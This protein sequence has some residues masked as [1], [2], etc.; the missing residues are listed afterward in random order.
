M[1]IIASLRFT[2][3]HS[4]YR[5]FNPIFLYLVMQKYAYKQKIYG[6]TK[7]ELSKAQNGQNP[8]DK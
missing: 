6:G 4:T 7:V 8:I 2:K 3:S 1:V 5:H